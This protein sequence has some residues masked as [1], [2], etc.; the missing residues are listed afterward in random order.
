MSHWNLDPSLIYV[1][2][3][4]V[5]YWVGGRRGAVPGS[6]VGGVKPGFQAGERRHQLLRE[7]SFWLGLAS[8]V[9]ATCSPIDYY[10]GQLVMIHMDQHIILLTVSPPLILMG[11]PWP[12]MWRALPLNT[13]TTAG[14]A[15]AQ[16]WWTA[17]LRFLSRPI[18][19][20]IM[21]NGFMLMW[22]L[23]A[24]YN[25]TLY[26][27]WIHDLEHTTYFF[28]GLLF[29]AHVIDPGP[30][31]AELN[32]LWR[33]MYVIGAMV[34][35]WV[36]AIALVI[37]PHVL[38]PYYAHLASRPWGISAIEDQQM[39][40]GMLWVLGSISYTIYI[41]IAFGRWAAPEASIPKPR[42]AVTT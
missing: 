21:F 5:L 22:H 28:T 1:G 27:R 14:R 19:A 9:L 6:R 15:I 24:L 20:F 11:R 31:R 40:G 26:H 41:L 7:I 2:L 4:A 25:A 10:S 12:R 29:W 42:T 16:A 23:P 33:A 32:W 39:G 35:G 18:P 8:I 30:L 34:V 17:P 3:A 37:Y 38:Y 36:L 13:R